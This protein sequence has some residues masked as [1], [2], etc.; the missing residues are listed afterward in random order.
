M[1]EPVPGYTLQVPVNPK[2][3]L[4]PEWTWKIAVVLDS[5]QGIADVNSDTQVLAILKQNRSQ[6]RT[7]TM[8]DGTRKNVND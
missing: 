5:G 7:I 8:P 3:I 4:A 2:E 1:T 6:V